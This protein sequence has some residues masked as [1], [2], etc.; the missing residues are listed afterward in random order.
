MLSFVSLVT[1]STFVIFALI[2]QTGQRAG[3]CL[4]INQDLAQCNEGKAATLFYKQC[5]VKRRAP[6]KRHARDSAR[7]KYIIGGESWIFYIQLTNSLRSHIFIK[8]N[9]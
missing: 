6:L 2:F 4:R 7:A 8:P 9:H 1:L 3:G 5:V